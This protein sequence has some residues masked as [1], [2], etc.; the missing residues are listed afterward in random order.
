MRI[1][2]IYIKEFGPYRDWSFI[3]TTSGVQVIYGPNESGKTSL[4]EAL[5]FLLFG[6]KSKTYGYG[7]GHLI[8][9]REGVTYHIGRDGKN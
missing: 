8:V 2:E 5:R 3:P 9:E 4:L 6:K 7:S 1:K